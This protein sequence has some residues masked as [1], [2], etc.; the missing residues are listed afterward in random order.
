MNSNHVSDNFMH[1]SPSPAILGCICIMAWIIDLHINQGQGRALGP[2]D[3][4]LTGASKNIL[5][6]LLHYK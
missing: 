1:S 2:S 6:N 5:S 4:T 3:R